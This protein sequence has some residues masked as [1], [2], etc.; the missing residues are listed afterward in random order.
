MNSAYAYALAILVGAAGAWYVEAIRWDNDVQARDV[1]AAQA[2]TANVDA[3][4]VQLVKSRAEAEVLRSTFLDYKAGSANE[5][6]KLTVA[7]SAGRSRLLVHAS[8][9]TVQPTGTVASGASGAT[10][11]LDASARQ[12][13]YDLRSGISDQ[14]ALLQ[15]CRDT[16]IKRSAAK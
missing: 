16:L 2:I 7:V 8:C 10:V 15:L 1:A 14:F 12:G 5:I 4:N 6:K 11:E 13:Y 3:V 9:P